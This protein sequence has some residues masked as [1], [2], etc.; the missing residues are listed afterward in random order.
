MKKSILIFG[1]ILFLLLASST[2]SIAQDAIETEVFYAYERVNYECRIP[3]VKPLPL[4]DNAKGTTE[5]VERRS[6]VKGLR[7]MELETLL[8]NMPTD[9][10]KAI[11][12]EIPALSKKLDYRYSLPFTKIKIKISFDKSGNVDRVNVDGD[13]LDE[14]LIKALEDALFEWKFPNKQASESL[15]VGLELL[16]SPIV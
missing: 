16:L 10:S 7:L 11:Q 14:H 6:L 12:N 13:K 15:K 5:S 1:N 9:L 2:L 8:G 4:P 3:I